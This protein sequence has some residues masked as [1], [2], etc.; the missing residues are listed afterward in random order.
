MAK[1]ALNSELSQMYFIFFQEGSKLVFVLKD[2]LWRCSLH[3]APQLKDA[4]RPKFRPTTR[5]SWEDAKEDC[6]GN[7]LP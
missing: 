6:H 5:L 4:P 1:G 7:I 2:G 3:K